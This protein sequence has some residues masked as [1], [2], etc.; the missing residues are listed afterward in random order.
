MTT[1]PTRIPAAKV[2]AVKA[3]VARAK[4]ARDLPRNP[5]SAQQIRL[6]CDRAMFSRDPQSTRPPPA[7]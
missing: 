3:A 7:G 5:M 2:A 1:A 4:A 6:W